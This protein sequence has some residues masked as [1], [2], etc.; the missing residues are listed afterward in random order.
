MSE[1]NYTEHRALMDTAE[2]LSP[3]S[4]APTVRVENGQTLRDDF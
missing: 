2:P 3:P 4:S 1:R